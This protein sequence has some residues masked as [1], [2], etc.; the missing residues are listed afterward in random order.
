[1]LIE[2]GF[3]PLT[4]LGLLMCLLFFLFFSPSHAKIMGEGS[5]NHAPPPPLFLFEVEVSSRAPIP[6]LEVKD[7]STVAQ[8]ADMTVDERFLTNCA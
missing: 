7:Q 5:M 1:M 4:K 6:S 3:F 2:I 8:R